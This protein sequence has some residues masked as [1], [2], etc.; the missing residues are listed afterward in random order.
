MP[1]LDSDPG[2]AILKRP[3]NPDLPLRN[4]R[5]SSERL[6]L[7][8]GITALALS[9]GTPHNQCH[10]VRS[11]AASP[12]PVHCKISYKKAQPKSKGKKT[13]PW[14]KLY[15]NCAFSAFDSA[16]HLP[17]KTEPQPLA[18]FPA[19]ESGSGIRYVS[20]GHRIARA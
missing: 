9:P 4:Q 2:L 17:P 1:I 14:R 6:A 8:T 7:V 20:T 3:R 15:G 16:A 13:R 19:V 5:V 10:E 12:T 18:S 11:A